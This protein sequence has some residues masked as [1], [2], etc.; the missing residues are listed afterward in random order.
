[1]SESGAGIDG[2]ERGR[3]KDLSSTARPPPHRTTDRHA[4][5]EEK[6]ASACMRATPLPPGALLS[7]EEWRALGVSAQRLAGPAL[8]TVFRG[9]S[10]PTSAPASVNTMCRVLQRRVLPGAVISHTTAAAILGIAIPWWV[11]REMGVLSSA[12]YLLDGK[13]VVPSTPPVP[14]GG[15]APVSSEGTGRGAG[16]GGSAGA[17]AGA[18][19]DTMADAW[20]TRVESGLPLDRSGFRSVPPTAVRPLIEPPLL[21]CRI[22]PGRQR[23]AGPHVVVHRTSRRPSFTYRGLDL[24]HPYVVLLELAS[25]LEHDDLVIAVDSLISRDP[26]LRGASLEA[27][28]AATDSYEARWGAPALRKALLDARPNTDSP[29]ETRTRLLLLRAGFPE[30][31]IN[32]PVTDPGTETT[33]YLDLAFPEYKIGVE[34]DGDYHRTVKNQ[35]RA[36][37]ARKDSLASLGWDLRTVNSQDIKEPR[38]ALD[39]LHRSF[40]RAGARP[41]AASNWSGRAL[42]LLGRSL[43]PPATT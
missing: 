38:R 17:G 41:P 27:I 20:A 29:G 26:P 35:W 42:E 7:R 32:D 16:R 6:L 39:A 24:S 28:W 2:V 18:G 13:R 4:V 36:D 30:P 10:T 40:A 19:R 37:Q 1:M 31:V 11:D 14:H 9:F 3:G 5:C 23:S 43:R 15:H 22:D 34:Y 33:R 8:I 12:S 21:H 25:M